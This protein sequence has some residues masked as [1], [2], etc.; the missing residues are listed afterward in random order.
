MVQPYE[1]SPARRRELDTMVTASL[2]AMDMPG[3]AEI[4]ER[5]VDGQLDPAEGIAALLVL[6]GEYERR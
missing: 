2:R 1:Q 5:M 3:G 6:S 4:L